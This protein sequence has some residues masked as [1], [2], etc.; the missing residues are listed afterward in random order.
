M[1]THW[2]AGHVIAQLDDL[3]PASVQAIITSPPYYGLRD[4]GLAPVIWAPVRYAPMAGLPEMAFPAHADPEAF[5]A[6]DHDWS[7][8]QDQHAVREAP[9]HGK[10]RTSDRSYG[11]DT[12]RRFDGN[13]QKHAHGQFCRQCGAWRGCLGL[14]PSPE[15]YIG[16]LVQ[17][18]RAASRVLRPDG[19]LWM[20]LGDAYSSGGRKYRDS[21]AKLDAR[22][23]DCRPPATP[24]IKPKDLYGIPWRAALALQA[25]GWY[26]R[27]D[28]IWAKGASFAKTWHGNPMPES[29]TDRPVRAHEFIFLFSRRPRYFYDHVSV[30]EAAV[31]QPQM[32]GEP[33]RRNLRDVWAV[34]T[35]PFK[36]AH[37]AVF[38]PD[39]VAPMIAASTPEIGCCPACGAPWRR[40]SLRGAAVDTGGRERQV[41]QARGHLATQG[42]QGALATGIWHGRVH[43]GWQPGCA[44]PAHTPVPSTVLDCFG[45]AGT[46]ALVARQMGRDAIHIEANPAYLAIAQDRL[47]PDPVFPECQHACL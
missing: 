28:I 19:T 43:A 9:I 16:H 20:N 36:G 46:T 23:M 42:R 1:T 33:S 47:G 2:H 29:V 22:G 41:V 18:F 25:D 30:Q 32:V 11:G 34:T 37:F 24:G 13:H 35:K 21:D 6:C 5:A 14:E 12:S 15:L 4:Y 10:T 45:G 44:C 8:W 26:L 39:L 40:L 3:A 17:V 7:D 31:T 27:S 38:P